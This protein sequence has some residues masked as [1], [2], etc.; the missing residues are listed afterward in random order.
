MI[1]KSDI[2]SYTIKKFVEYEKIVLG[3]N[4][5]FHYFGIYDDSEENINDMPEDYFT[6]NGFFRKINGEYLVKYY[7][8][9]CKYQ[10]FFN[11]DLEWFNRDSLKKWYYL[12]EMVKFNQKS[13][14]FDLNSAINYENIS[15]NKDINNNEKK[16]NNTFSKILNI[17][18][19]NNSQN[20]G[21]DINIT[22]NNNFANNSDNVNNKKN[23]KFNNDNI[24]NNNYIS[25][26]LNNSIENKNNKDI[27]IKNE[28]NFN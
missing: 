14:I 5:L 28:K 25:T 21:K 3:Q 13:S 27:S 6:V 11:S 9:K 17:I 24:I 20:Y 8:D 26:N 16:S 10:D 22:I 7:Y 19:P 18:Y 15:D 2:K 4:N 23:E 1:K 12:R